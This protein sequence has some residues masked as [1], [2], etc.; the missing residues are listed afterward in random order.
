MPFYPLL[1]PKVSEQGPAA[2]Q[3]SRQG[4]HEGLCWNKPPVLH[5]A[6]WDWF[7]PWDG[8]HSPRMPTVEAYFPGGL[9][10]PSAT[11]RHSTGQACKNPMR[12]SASGTVTETSAHAEGTVR[13]G[14]AGV[15]LLGC[16]QRAFFSGSVSERCRAP[17]S[18]LIVLLSSTLTLPRCLRKAGV[19][20]DPE[21][22]Y[23]TS[24]EKSV[25]GTHRQF[26]MLCKKEVS[27]E[28][29]FMRKVSFRGKHAHR[30]GMHM[31]M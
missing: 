23:A 8:I 11:S 26:A 14:A 7:S 5:A 3:G 30:Q 15:S 6:G 1:S 29:I 2:A 25:V 27:S 18:R 4:S 16:R 17:D 13:T 20:T 12:S 24:V 28:H 10:Q 19:K 21:L 9:L 22:L 31:H